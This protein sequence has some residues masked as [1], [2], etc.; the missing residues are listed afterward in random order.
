MSNDKQAMNCGFE[1]RSGYHASCFVS[2]K[3]PLRQRK[4]ITGTIQINS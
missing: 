2:M 1:S 4:W 3:A